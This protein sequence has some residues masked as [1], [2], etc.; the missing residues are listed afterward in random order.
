MLNGTWPASTVLKNT[1]IMTEKQQLFVETIESSLHMMNDDE[2]VSVYNQYAKDNRYEE[3]FENDDEFF[4]SN[5]GAEI[6][7]AVSAT[8]WGDFKPH[9]KYAMLNSIGNVDSAD[10]PTD[11]DEFDTEDVARHI[12]ENMNEFDSYTEI[13]D[14]IQEARHEWKNIC[15][16]E[17][18]EDENEPWE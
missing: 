8:H 15:Q 5:F 10:Y 13:Y 6:M 16:D 3:I 18:R 17:G 7:K 11:F 4:E 14:A 1:E 9:H 2:L 12:S